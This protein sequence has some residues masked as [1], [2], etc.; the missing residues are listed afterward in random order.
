VYI[1]FFVVFYLTCKSTNITIEIPMSLID[2]KEW[3]VYK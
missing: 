2:R 3:F 1:V